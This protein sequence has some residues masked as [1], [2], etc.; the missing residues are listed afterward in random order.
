MSVSLHSPGRP[1]AYNRILNFR[2]E[3]V[4]CCQLLHSSLNTQS[5][6]PYRVMFRDYEF[7]R[8]LNF[9]YF[10]STKFPKYEFSRVLNFRY[11]FKNREMAKISLAKIF[12]RYFVK[13]GLTHKSF[14][15]YISLSSVKGQLQNFVVKK[16]CR[17]TN[18]TCLFF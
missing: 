5:Y 9:S 18:K 13:N 4:C 14:L 3:E 8:I 2:A 6:H 16:C 11:F 15:S 10:V 7:S 17:W 12:T 1:G